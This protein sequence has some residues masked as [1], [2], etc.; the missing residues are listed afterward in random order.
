M[1]LFASEKSCRVVRAPGNRRPRWPLSGLAVLSFPVST[2]RR[3]FRRLRRRFTPVSKT[4]IIT[5][6]TSSS[7]DNMKTYDF[8]RPLSRPPPRVCFVVRRRPGGTARCRYAPVC[9][10]DSNGRRLHRRTHE[11]P[12]GK[13]DKIDGP[14]TPD[15]WP[16]PGGGRTRRKTFLAGEGA[17]KGF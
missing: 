6:S 1:F 11:K 14:A 3:R 15:A 10:A 8:Y 12:I 16:R 2:I 4:D 17:M 13:S 7:A 5:Q 9:P